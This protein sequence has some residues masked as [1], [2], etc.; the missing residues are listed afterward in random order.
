[1]IS[2][3]DDWTAAYYQANVTPIDIF[4]RASVRN[5]QANDLLHAIAEAASQR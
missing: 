1:M 4:V 2:V 3:N 5:P